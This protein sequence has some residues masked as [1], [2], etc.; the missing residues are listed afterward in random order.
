MVLKKTLLCCVN[1]VYMYQA[2]KVSVIGKCVFISARR[3][4]QLLTLGGSG[5]V[6]N[7]AADV[8][9]SRV[10]SPPSAKFAFSVTSK[11]ILH[12]RHQHYNKGLATREQKP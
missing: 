2:I 9:L 3:T 4:D 11:R 10:F 5:R 6:A 1:M 12:Q 7:Q 8:L